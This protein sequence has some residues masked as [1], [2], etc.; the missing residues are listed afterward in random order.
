MREQ[1]DPRLDL[2][3]DRYWDGVFGGDPAGSAPEPLDPELAATVR[4]VHELDTAPPANPVFASRLWEELMH[5]HGIA[6]EVSLRSPSPPAGRLAQARPPTRP[7]PID[8]PQS[9]RRWVLAQFATALLLVVTLAAIYFAF[10]QG[11]QPANQPATP[12]PGTPIPAPT[13]VPAAGDW[14]MFLRDAARSNVADAG[15]V[16]QPSQLWRV[17]AG[18]PCDTAPVVVGDVVY[19]ACGDGVLYALDAATGAERWRFTVSKA[20]VKLAAVAGL[21]YVVDG[22]GT[23]YAIDASTGQER[24]RAALAVG[25]EPVVDDGLLVVGTAGD[26]LVGLDATT[27]QE[28]WRFAPENMG[29]IHNPAL[30]RGV[31]YVGFGTGWLVAV[32]A[33]TG[34]LRWRAEVE[35]GP[36]S[37]A[38]T[39]R[40]ADGVVYLGDTSEAG[41]LHAFDAETG[42]VLW[43]SDRTMGDPTVSGGLG[44][45]GGV[46]TLYAVDVTTGAV[47]WQV[48]V[49]GSSRGIIVAGEL[50]YIFSEGDR[51]LYALETAT[52]QE[53]WRYDLGEGISG[54]FSIAGGVIY[55]GTG[56]GG[57]V[58]LG[59]TPG[60]PTPNG[61]AVVAAS[62]VGTPATPSLPVAMIASPEAAATPEP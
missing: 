32:D 57:I 22:G 27:G 43:T 39:A 19:V 56:F 16:V 6:G 36:L 62:P 41:R 34:G 8:L 14:S 1:R 51:I 24:W 25:R 44:F 35:I 11:N 48:S 47:H 26:A 10:F 61:A 40:V 17:Q 2:T 37:H 23:L 7:Q 50:V 28:R 55:V 49:A 42:A 53:R 45:T 54:S 59:E 58:A 38:G 3:L 12:L 18:G 52:G 46:D 15:P 31:V 21:V 33:A 5:A 4:R 13:T 29:G 9:R 30:A 20:L 60:T